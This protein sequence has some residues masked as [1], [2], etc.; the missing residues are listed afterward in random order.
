MMTAPGSNP[1]AAA[2][3]ARQA[4]FCRGGGVATL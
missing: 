4:L 1:W 3:Q 2:A